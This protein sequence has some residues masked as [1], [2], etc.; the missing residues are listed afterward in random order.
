MNEKNLQILRYHSDFF[1]DQV[2]ILP[3]LSPLRTPK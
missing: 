1:S 2:S 3:P